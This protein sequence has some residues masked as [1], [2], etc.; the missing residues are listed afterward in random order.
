MNE[1]KRVRRSQVARC[2][3][4]FRQPRRQLYFQFQLQRPCD[5]CKEAN[6]FAQ[7]AVGKFEANQ[8]RS[9]RVFSYSREST[10]GMWVSS[11]IVPIIG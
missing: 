8:P 11:L 6:A 10:L 4:G 5:G 9:L 2:V 3:R 7:H 1:L